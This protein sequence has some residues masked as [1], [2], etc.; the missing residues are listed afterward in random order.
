[1][2]SLTC[3][4][5]AIA[6]TSSWMTSNLL[7]YQTIEFTHI[8]LP[9][10]IYRIFNPSLSLHSNPPLTPTD[11]VR[12]LG[13][14]FDSS[15]TFS[16]QISCLSSACN[17]HIRDLR[18]V[19]KTP[20]PKQHPLSLLVLYTLNETI[21]TRYLNL[22]YKISSTATAKLPCSRNNWNHK[23]EHIYNHP[24]TQISALAQ[25]RRAHPL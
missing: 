20:D 19:R 6:D 16:K 18:R 21:V 15:L 7:S 8:V 24:C 2:Y 10:Q 1:M 9:Q 13:F 17:N 3:H 23:T 11:S 22:P 25:N 12:N 5:D 14:I 4:L